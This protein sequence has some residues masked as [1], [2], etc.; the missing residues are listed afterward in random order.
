MPRPLARK[1]L[2]TESVPDD[3]ETIDDKLLQES[4]ESW[5]TPTV[6]EDSDRQLHWLLSMLDTMHTEFFKEVNCQIVT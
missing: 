2:K 3:D 1:K 5:K 6:L 4:V